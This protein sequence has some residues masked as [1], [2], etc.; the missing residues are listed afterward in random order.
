MFQTLLY[1]TLKVAHEEVLQED[2]LLHL[3][4]RIKPLIWPPVGDLKV[5]S[6]SALHSVTQYNIFFDAV[7]RHIKVIHRKKILYIA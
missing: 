1:A 5:I 2:D 4:Q 3:L 6:N 7:S